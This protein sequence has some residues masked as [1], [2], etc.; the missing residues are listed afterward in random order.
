MSKIGRND[1]CPC[2]SGKKYKHCHLALEQAA[3]SERRALRQAQDTLFPKLAEAAQARPEIFPTALEQFWDGRYGVEQMGDIDDEEPRGAERFLTW[4]VFDYVLPDGRTLLQSLADAPESL[5]LD[6]HEARL[7]Q[8]WGEVRLRP[9]LIEQ[10]TKGQDLTVRDMLDEARYR[11]VDHAAS[12]RLEDGEVIV[13]HLVPVAGDYYIVGA[14]AHLTEDTAEKLSEFA[15]LHL[16]AYRRE[17]PEASWTDLLRERSQVLNHFVMQLPSEAPVPGLM[18]EILLKTRT[19]LA[20]SGLPLGVAGGK[21]E[22]QEEKQD[23]PPTT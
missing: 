4:L 3:E 11:V 18:D 12:R 23:A 7:L 2:G 1:P 13:G 20:L 10:R 6:Q 19:A 16:E 5:E 15:A 14:A 17:H 9:Y 21:A 22:Q 8:A